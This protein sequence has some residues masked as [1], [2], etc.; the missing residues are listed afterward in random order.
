MV[1][2]ANL[3]SSSVVSSTV[4]ECTRDCVTLFTAF[5]FSGNFDPA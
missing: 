2:A 5:A 1:V 4:G 3:S